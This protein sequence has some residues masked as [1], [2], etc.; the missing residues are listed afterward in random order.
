MAHVATHTPLDIALEAAE[1]LLDLL[2]PHCLRLEV[3]GSVRRQKPDVKDLEL[4]AV[5]LVAESTAGQLFATPQN[6]LDVFLEQVPRNSSSR[7]CRPA[8]PIGARM[9]AWGPKYKVL[10][11]QARRRWLAVDLFIVQPGSWGPQFAIRTGPSDF[12]RCLVTERWKGGAMPRGH[13]L[14]GGWLQHLVDEQWEP[15]RLVEESEFFDQLQLPT[16]PAPE[17]TERRLREYLSGRT[18]A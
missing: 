9:P 10:L 18:T 2:R 8:K 11:W 1:Q 6:A 5:P 3:A 12:S 7:L 16:W 17:R 13:R 4:V 15:I 14:H